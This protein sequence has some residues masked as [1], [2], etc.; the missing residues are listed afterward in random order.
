[1]DDSSPLLTPDEDS[2]PLLTPVDESTAGGDLPRAWK[3]KRTGK[4]QRRQMRAFSPAFDDVACPS[5]SSRSQPNGSTVSM[6]AS[7]DKY[8]RLFMV[9]KGKY[10]H[11]YKAQ[12]IYTKEIVACK[13]ATVAE[14]PILKGFPLHLVREIGI[15]R[16]LQDCKSIVRLIEVVASRRGDSIVVMEYCQASLEELLR[17]EHHSSLSMGEVCDFGISR[18]AFADDP[19]EGIIMAPNLEPP[20]QCV[21]LYYRSIELLL[22]ERHYGPK[23]DIWSA[24]CILAE[25]LICANGRIQSFF[26]GAKENPNRNPQH[27][28]HQIFQILGCPTEES[29]PGCTR[30]PSWNTSAPPEIRETYRGHTRPQEEKDFLTHYFLEGDGKMN[31]QH[32]LTNALFELLASMLTMNPADRA[33]AKTAMEANWF[34]ELP[35]PE[36]HNDHWT[37]FGEVVERERVKETP[38]KRKKDDAQTRAQKEGRGIKLPSRGATEAL[39]ATARK[40]CVNASVRPTHVPIQAP[41]NLRA[42]HQESHPVTSNQLRNSSG[43]SAPNPSAAQPLTV[44]APKYSAAL[45]RPVNDYSAP[46]MDLN[47]ATRN[48]FANNCRDTIMPSNDVNCW[49][50]TMTVFVPTVPPPVPMVMPPVPPL[51]E[52]T[53]A[54]AGEHLR[55]EQHTGAHIHPNNMLPAYGSHFGGRLLPHGVPSGKETNTQLLQNASNQPIYHR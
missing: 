48:N 23:L 25:I 32:R 31:I 3:R 2:D 50:N 35:L 41:L 37:K 20:H 11:V 42:F 22:G 1:M 30:L 46:R 21:S 14:C 34:K 44:N 15:L 54:H 19:I 9:G 28:M 55:H 38:H 52:T 33:T 10:G 53:A 6:A 7:A 18:F 47:M 39:S 43:Y 51:V 8:R 29:W 36:W 40:R 5:Q 24:G 27:L 17:S 49:P 16:R 4:A 45:P 26:G 12:N 13:V